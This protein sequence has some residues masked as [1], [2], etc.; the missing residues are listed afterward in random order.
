M[1]NEQEEKLLKLIEESGFATVKYLA[2]VM[3]T[4]ES[5]V[6]RRLNELEKAGLIRRSYGGAE[7]AGNSINPSV[8]LRLRKNHHEKDI[9]GKMAASFVMND[10]IIFIDASSTALH[11]APYLTDKKGLT[12]YT[13]GTELCDILANSGIKVFCVGGEYNRL[14][15][16]FTGEYAISMAT[17]I[18]Y[19]AFFFSGSGYSNGIVSDY[20]AAETHLRKAVMRN[21]DKCYFL[22]DSEK[23]GKQSAYILCGKNALTEIISERGCEN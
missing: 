7:L 6:R 20:N 2:G 15:R 4:S 23:F 1:K 16:G 21:S 13:Y 14:S 18:H 3:Y 5:T 8:E 12:V 10:S 17:E 22:C 9:I 19:D 11:M